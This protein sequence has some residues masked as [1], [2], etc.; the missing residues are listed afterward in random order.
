MYK[1]EED[2]WVGGLVGTEGKRRGD[3]YEVFTERMKS[4]TFFF[5]FFSF[6]LTCIKG[7]FYVVWCG[8]WVWRES[9]G[10]GR[11]GL[12]ERLLGGWGNNKAI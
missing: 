12:V 8:S 7:A 10:V 6:P 5:F 3:E 9:K 2:G 4:P 11:G 1:K